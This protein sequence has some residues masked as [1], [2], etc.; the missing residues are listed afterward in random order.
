MVDIVVEVVTAEDTVVVTVVVVVVVVAGV[1]VVLVSLVASVGPCVPAERPGPAQLLWV[2]ARVEAA[3]SSSS[4]AT[5][6]AVRRHRD[7]GDLHP[8]II[9]T[10]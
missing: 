4:A 8:G 2:A 9:R 7:Q 1:V 10:Y 3:A 6:A 5:M